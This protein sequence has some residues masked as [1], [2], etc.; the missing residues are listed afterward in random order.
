MQRNP[1]QQSEGSIKHAAI[2][3]G[4]HHH[5]HSAFAPDALEPEPILNQFRNVRQSRHDTL[6]VL[7]SPERDYIFIK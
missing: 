5:V 7:Y 3:Q 4:S 2:V 1:P 6:Y